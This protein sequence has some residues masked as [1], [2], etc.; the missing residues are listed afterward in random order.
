MEKYENFTE[1]QLNVIKRYIHIHLH[2]KNPLFVSDL[3]DCANNNNIESAIIFDFCMD[4]IKK[5]R[6]PAMVLSA[7]MYVF[8]HMRITQSIRVVPV[9]ERVVNNKT[10]YQNCQI[11][12]AFC[13]FRI[14]MNPQYL[15]MIEGLVAFNKELQIVLINKM[16][17]MNYNNSK[18][19]FF[20]YE[21]NAFRMPH[22][23]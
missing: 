12:A 1:Q 10:Y 23:D 17:N 2:D 8:E 20:Y 21:K 16:L 6:A 15:Q 14:T 4:T 13:L 5:R 18:R 11:I 3:I 9:L 19:Y 22:A 7:I